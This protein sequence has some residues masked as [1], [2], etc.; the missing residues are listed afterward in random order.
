MKCNVS[1]INM[2]ASACLAAFSGMVYADDIVRDIAFPSLTSSYTNGSKS[3]MLALNEAEIVQKDSTATP[4]AQL[5]EFKPATFSGSNAHKYMGLSTVA[6]VGLTMLTAPGEGCEQNCTGQ[7]PPRQTNGTHAK[8]AK[9]AAF[10]AAATVATGLLYHWDDFHME[11]GWTDP[12]NMHVM[13]G[14]AGALLMMYAV[15]K[16]AK[17]SVP[18]SHAAIAE[19][20]GVAMAVAIKLTW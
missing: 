5:A 19:L 9:A 18:T 1:F 3:Y 4:V 10:M 6:L 12:D 11:D 8:L 20:G 14:G 16:S 2:F 7:Q 17:S 15:N 13:L